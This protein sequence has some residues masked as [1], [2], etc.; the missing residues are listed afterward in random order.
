M[1]K[2]LLAGLLLLAFGVPRV[3]AEEVKIGTIR[4]AGAGASW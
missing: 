2:V 1:K 4:V 3:S